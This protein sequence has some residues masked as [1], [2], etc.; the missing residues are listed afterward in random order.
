MLMEKEQT[1]EKV[2]LIA[3][4]MKATELG[5]LDSN[6]SQSNQLSNGNFKTLKSEEYRSKIS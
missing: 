6:E 3:Y 2:D 4:S 5:R 1:K